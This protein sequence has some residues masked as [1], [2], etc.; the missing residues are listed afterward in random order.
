M[1]CIAIFNDVLVPWDRVWADGSG[2]SRDVLNAGN[3]GGP[4]GVIVQTN[5]R[6]LS[7]L[8]TCCAVAVRLADAV[9]IDGFLHVQEKLGE[10]LLTLENM[11]A[12]FYGAEAMATEGPDG[13]WGVYGGGLV[14]FQMMQGRIYSRFVE[15]IQT[16]AAGGFFYA[17]SD[18]DFDSE[19]LRSDIDKFVRGRPGVSARERVA[20]F[21][22]AWDLTGEAFGQR[23]QQYTRYYGGDPVRNVAGFFLGYPKDQLN[24]LVERIFAGPEAAMAIPISPAHP[25]LPPVLPP[26]RPESLTATYPLASHPRQS[27]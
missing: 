16:L 18:A 20:I 6:L 12:A 19:E 17:P 2:A 25:E 13:A 15:I 7:S 10:M 26:K 3:F 27:A 9:G 8:E 11:K 14:Y 23:L 1:D 4:N 24:Q 21:K 22:L 5:A